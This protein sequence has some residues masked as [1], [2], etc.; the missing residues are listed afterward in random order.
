VDRLV[1]EPDGAEPVDLGDVDRGRLER[2]V[3]RE[4]AERP[5][6]GVEPGV[7]V[8]VGRVSR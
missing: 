2:Q 1:R 8:V 4:V 3:D 7:P 5:G 6:P